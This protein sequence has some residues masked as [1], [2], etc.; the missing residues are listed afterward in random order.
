MFLHFYRTKM[1]HIFKLRN[2]TFFVTTRLDLFIPV[3]Y[4]LKFILCTTALFFTYSDLF[5]I[6]SLISV[7]PKLTQK[8]KMEIHVKT[9]CM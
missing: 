7:T 4:W 5:H 8:L 9:K 1:L 2:W 6:S 3:G